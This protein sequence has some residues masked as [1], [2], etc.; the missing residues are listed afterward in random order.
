MEIRVEVVEGT[1]VAVKVT[2]MLGD[3]PVEAGE[4]N[5]RFFLMVDGVQ[6]KDTK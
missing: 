2:D 6:C 1:R 3:E 4:M 5:V